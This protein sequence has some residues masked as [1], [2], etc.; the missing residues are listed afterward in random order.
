MSHILLSQNSVVQ[1]QLKA[2]VPDFTVGSLVKVH[3]KI[4]ESGKER[5]QIF[6]GLVIQRQHGK[7]INGTFTVLKVASAAIKVER[8]FPLHSPMISKIEVVK[9][10][11]STRANL[12]YLHNVKDPEKSLR[13]KAVVR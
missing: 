2:D 9:L 5:I 8:T 11:R 4:V 6:E 7:G 13:V 1:A 12:D 3:Y 10:Q